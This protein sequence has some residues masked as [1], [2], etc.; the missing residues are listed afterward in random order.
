MSDRFIFETIFNPKNIKSLSDQDPLY[1]FAK[2][3]EVEFTELVDL[4]RDPNRLQIPLIN[5][6]MTL[7]WHLV[8]DKITPTAI[9]EVHQMYFFAEVYATKSIGLVL[10]PENWC[11]TLK[12]NPHYQMGAMVFCA[13]QARDY[14]NHKYPDLEGTNMNRA[15]AYESELLHWFA[16]NA[17]SFQP[18]DYQQI[19]MECFPQGISATNLQY[20]GRGYDGVFPPYPYNS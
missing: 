3:L 20:S 7:F 19:I 9:T 16:K 1:I 8:G 6:L 15:K 11:E 10:C 14:W 4:M 17:E 13:S 12:S 18:N 2:Q 5:E